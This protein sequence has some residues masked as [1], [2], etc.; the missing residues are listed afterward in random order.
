MARLLGSDRTVARRG[1]L[2]LLQKTLRGKPGSLLHAGPPCSTWVWINS[3]TSG[4][5]RADPNGNTCQPSVYD[6][7]TPLG[8]VCAATGFR[9][10]TIVLEHGVQ[11]HWRVRITLRLVLVLMLALCRE[12]FFVVE[13]PRSSVM[14]YWEPFLCLTRQI[15]HDLKIGWTTA[16]MPAPQTYPS[17]CDLFSGGWD[18]LVPSL[19]SRRSCSGLRPGLAL[20]QVN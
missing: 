15:L 12:M 11:S 2:K 17:A 13:Q 6:A 14:P 8:H 20:R 4:R 1:F 7:N 16:S 19:P 10:I 5:S 18:P 9:R 3:A